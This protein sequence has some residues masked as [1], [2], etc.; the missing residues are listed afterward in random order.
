MS[1]FIAD[2]APV[3]PRRLTA[4]WSRPKESII[5]GRAYDA[6]E[7]ANG[8]NRVKPD[9]L[10]LN[11]WITCRGEVVVSMVDATPEISGGILG[12]GRRLLAGRGYRVHLL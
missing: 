11:P 1:V 12:G 10:I 7:A 5:V 3:T 4:T 8:I 9:T 6:A 2:A